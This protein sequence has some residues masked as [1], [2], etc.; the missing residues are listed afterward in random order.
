MLFFAFHLSLQR[1]SRGFSMNLNG[2]TSRK[3]FY[4]FHF[5]Q[6]C[7]SHSEINR[8]QSSLFPSLS[9]FNLF[10][11]D[12]CLRSVANHWHTLQQQR[13][14]S[15]RNANNFCISQRFLVMKKGENNNT[16]CVVEEREM[17]HKRNAFLWVPPCLLLVS[18]AGGGSLSSYWMDVS[19]RERAAKDKGT[20]FFFFLSQFRLARFSLS[21]SSLLSRT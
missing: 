5:I 9:L 6:K 16:H 17:Y 1:F 19:R 4:R 3:W 18:L 15:R 12:V 20:S 11:L 7:L 13:Q 8:Q 2:I 10:L 21:L 14:F